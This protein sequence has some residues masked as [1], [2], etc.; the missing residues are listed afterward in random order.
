MTDPRA[1]HQRI[2]VPVLNPSLRPRD[3]TPA[4]RHLT[5]L[6]AP[7]VPAGA[8]DLPAAM[9]ASGVPGALWCPPPAAP[10]VLGGVVWTAEDAGPHAASIG[11]AL[12]VE[13]VGGAE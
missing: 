2:P 7:T 5:P 11:L 10:I 8:L 1:S 9:L 12:A 3:E 6:P 13:T 4:L